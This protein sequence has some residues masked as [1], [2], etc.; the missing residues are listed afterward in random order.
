MRPHLSKT[1][2]INDFPR[3]NRFF[4]NRFYG[5]LASPEEV[6]THSILHQGKIVGIEVHQ[7]FNGGLNAQGL[8]I[9]QGEDAVPKLNDKY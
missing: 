2:Y 3:H 6:E 8:D 1:T 5:N 9:W 7:L 4:L